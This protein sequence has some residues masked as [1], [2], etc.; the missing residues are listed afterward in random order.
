VD[1]GYKGGKQYKESKI[2]LPH[3]DK[4]ISKQQRKKHSKRSAIEP[5]IGHLKQDYRLC[6]N[7]LKGIPGD[8][9]NV[10]LSAAAWNFRR[11]IILWLTEAIRRWL[12]TFKLIAGISRDFYPLNLK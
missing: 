4:N 10:I 6:R 3:P 11:R 1:R 12:L 2:F 9:I 5:V 8:N 7:F